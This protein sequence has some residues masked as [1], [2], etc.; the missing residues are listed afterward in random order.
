MAKKRHNYLLTVNQ[1]A[2]LEDVRSMYLV[3]RNLDLLLSG[4]ELSAKCLVT[5]CSMSV[6]GHI[7]SYVID[8]LSF[9]TLS[10][11]LKTV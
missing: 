6:L 11:S 7:I 3:T 5:G 2:P 8:R 9:R 1:K 10:S 4:G